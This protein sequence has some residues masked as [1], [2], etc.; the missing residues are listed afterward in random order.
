MRSSALWWGSF[1]STADS[2]TADKVGRFL[3]FCDAFEIPVL[4]LCRLY[5]IGAN[6]TVPIFLVGLRKACGLGAQGW[7]W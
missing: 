1:G 7:W 6:L 3:Q 4:S 5:L 2:Q